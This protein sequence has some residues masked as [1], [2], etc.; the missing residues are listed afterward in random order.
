MNR[1]TDKVGYTLAALENAAGQVWAS[2]SDNKTERVFRVAKKDDWIPSE[3]GSERVPT[4]KTYQHG[5]EK[6][7]PA[8]KHTMRK[9]T[10][11]EVFAFLKASKLAN[12][13][14]Q[15]IDIIRTAQKEASELMAKLIAGNLKLIKNEEG[16]MEAVDK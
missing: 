9:A 3:N 15:P 5:K 10:D 4:V 13:K 12:T 8:P 6:Y 16:K 7:K 14:D 1:D 2:D 11:L